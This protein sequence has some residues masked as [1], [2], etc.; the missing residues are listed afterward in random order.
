[1]RLLLATRPTYLAGMTVVFSPALNQ[2]PNLFASRRV[3]P[4]FTIIISASAA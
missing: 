1:M 4:A 2:S 3:V